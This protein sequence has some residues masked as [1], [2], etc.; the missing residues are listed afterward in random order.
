V[1]LNPIVGETFQ[2]EM[3]SGEMFYG[4]QISHRP[5]ITSWLLEDPDEDYVFYGSYKLN[6][7]LNGIQSFVGYKTG[8]MTLK[9]KDGTVYKFSKHPVMQVTGLVKGP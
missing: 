1:P 2:C 6:G 9:F 4:E 8:D 7:W 3:P 5:P